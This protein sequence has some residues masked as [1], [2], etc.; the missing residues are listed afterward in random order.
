VGAAVSGQVRARHEDGAEVQI[1]PGEAYV[2][3]PGHDAWVIG[4][5]P[6]VAYEFDSSHYA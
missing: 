2:I 6:F 1:G 3:E 5:E 4:S